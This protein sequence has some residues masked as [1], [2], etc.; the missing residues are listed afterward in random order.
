MKKSNTE[1]FMAAPDYGRS[2][3]GFSV[4]LL[5]PDLVRALVFQRDVLRAEVLHQDEDLLILRGYGN[6]PIRQGEQIL[7]QQPH[8]GDDLT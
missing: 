4:N 8:R 7:G 6:G 5:S 3:T 2:L 1:P